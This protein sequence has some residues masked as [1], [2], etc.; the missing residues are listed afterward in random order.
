MESAY[1]IEKAKRSLNEL[2][3]S[4]LEDERIKFNDEK[5]KKLDL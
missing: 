2:S 1:F 4:R 3:L 5:R